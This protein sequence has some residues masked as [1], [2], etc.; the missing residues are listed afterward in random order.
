MATEHWGNDTDKEG[1][2]RL[3]GI[4]L[5]LPLYLSQRHMKWP[6]MQPVPRT[7]R[8]P[9]YHLCHG[10]HGNEEIFGFH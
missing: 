7:E 2:N 9:A 5:P 6:G 8:Q 1:T 10:P 3:G 4:P